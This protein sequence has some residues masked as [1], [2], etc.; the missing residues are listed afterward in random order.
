M[1]SMRVVRLTFLILTGCSVIVQTG[2]EF[3]ASTSDIQKDVTSQRYQTTETPKSGMFQKLILGKSLR[4]EVIEIYGQPLSTYDSMADRPSQKQSSGGSPT[5]DEFEITGV[6][7]GRMI[8]RTDLKGVITDIIIA[9]RAATVTQLID[10]YGKGYIRKRYRFVECPGD[11]GSSRVVEDP[12]GSVEYL[13][14]PSLGIVAQE[15]D[16]R[17]LEMSFS[18]SPVS[19]SDGCD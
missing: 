15:R 6:F 13:E 2:C 8:V 7:A 3:T 12:D 5:F 18:L 16:G 10:E 17:V 14:Y 9:P 4:R 1:D 11:A 19:S